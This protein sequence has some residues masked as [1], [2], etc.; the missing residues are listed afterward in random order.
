MD[1][2][3]RTVDLVVETDA[4]LPMTGRDVVY[5]AIVAVDDGE[6]VYAGPRDDA[7]DRFVATRTLGDP[8]TVVFPGF[9]D[10]HAHAGAHF[11]GT[12][13]DDENIITA[14][15]DLWFPMEAAYDPDMT[16]A[17]ACLGMWDAVRSGVTTL[18]NDE[19]FPQAVAEAAERIGIRCLVANRI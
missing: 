2:E 4:L 8:D 15:Y 14:L 5:D 16:R 19:Y 17:A 9:V 11:F 3:P 6:I 13:C 12:L 18:G 10:T 1:A 7:R